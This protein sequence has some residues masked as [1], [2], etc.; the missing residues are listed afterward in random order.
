MPTKIRLALKVF[1]EPTF[2]NIIEKYDSMCVHYLSE[3]VV[4]K[5]LGIS[6]YVLGRIT[7]DL[8]VGENAHERNGR[9]NIGLKL[10]YM[11]QK[12]E[13]CSFFYFLWLYLNFDS[14]IEN[15]L[16]IW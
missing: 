1:Q 4:A 16:L 9:V 13:V 2:D 3:E 11:K 10:K 12:Q 5:R 15:G 8:I 6:V 7:G 14:R